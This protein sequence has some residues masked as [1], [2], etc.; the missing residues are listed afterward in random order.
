MASRPDRP[1]VVASPNSTPRRAPLGRDAGSV[2][3]SYASNRSTIHRVRNEVLWRYSMLFAALQ[4]LDDRQPTEPARYEDPARVDRDGE[5]V[6]VL[7][8]IDRFE[9]GVV[10]RATV[11]EER[12][13]GLRTRER[14]L[15][16]LHLGEGTRHGGR[17]RGSLG[18]AESAARRRRESGHV[19]ADHVALEP[20]ADTGCEV[21]RV[22]DP[23]AL[24]IEVLQLG[25]AEPPRVEGPCEDVG[26][27]VLA[28]RP[29][30]V[31][32]QPLLQ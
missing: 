26:A 8:V 21:A 9:S 10:V 28:D 29:P 25:T 13:S 24:W 15:V 2:A 31:E 1:T 14:H 5:E 11:E 17:C 7:V 6:A 12:R 30:D 19:V 27:I 4:V 18:D 22:E 23:A 3:C 20:E 16:D 32:Q